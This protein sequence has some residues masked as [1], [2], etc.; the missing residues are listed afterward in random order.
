M[1]IYTLI[2]ETKEDIK[3]VTK[4]IPDIKILDILEGNKTVYNA[5][6]SIELDIEA[7]AEDNGYDLSKEDVSQ[8]ASDILSRDYIWQHYEETISEM[9]HKRGVAR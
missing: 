1:K 9:V 8:I 3:K 5:I 2:I 6:A 7:Y 4:E